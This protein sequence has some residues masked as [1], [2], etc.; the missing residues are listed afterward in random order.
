MHFKHKYIFHLL[1][2]C[3]YRI[4]FDIEF[5]AKTVKLD[6]T[7]HFNFMLPVYTAD[8]QSSN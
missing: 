5:M 3:I 6:V 8:L 4:E 2:Y 1:I 7:L